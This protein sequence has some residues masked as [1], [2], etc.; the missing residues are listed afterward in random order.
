MRTTGFGA[1]PITLAVLTG[2]SAATLRAEPEEVRTYKRSDA[3]ELKLH[4]VTPVA[5]ACRYEA[6]MKTVGV[7]CDLHL[8]SGQKHG[9][10]ADQANGNPFYVRVIV[11]ADRFLASLGFLSCD[12]TL[13][14]LGTP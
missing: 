14:E 13:A 7:R 12:P 3:V 4:S 1:R 5:P 2:V 11:A 9:F 6:A 10:Y 8:Y